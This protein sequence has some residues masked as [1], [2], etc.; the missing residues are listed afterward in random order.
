MPSRPSAEIGGQ[1]RAHSLPRTCRCPYREVMDITR[2]RGDLLDKPGSVAERHPAVR[3]A[4]DA[5]YSP[6]AS[7]R[8]C[9]AP[10]VKGGSGPV[11]NDRPSR[12]RAANVMAAVALFAAE[13]PAYDF[14]IQQTSGGISL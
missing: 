2:G 10:A 14:R 4:L 7:V 9:V 3:T 12:D 13:F 5:R 6:S 8:Y 11:M 1:V